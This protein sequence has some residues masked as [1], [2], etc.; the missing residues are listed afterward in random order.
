M[1]IA[2]LDDI[3][4]L[5]DILNTNPQDFVMEAYADPLQYFEPDPANTTKPEEILEKLKN[6]DSSTKVRL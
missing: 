2:T 1:S 6:N 3:M 4:A 5:A